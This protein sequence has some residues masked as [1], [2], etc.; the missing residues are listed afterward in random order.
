MDNPKKIQQLLGEFLPHAQAIEWREPPRSSRLTLYVLLAMVLTAIVW[1]TFSEMDKL[2][3]GSGRLVTPLSNLVVQPLEPGILKSID[4]RVGQVVAK[5][6]VLATLDPT[7]ASADT[8][9]LQSRSDTLSLQVGRLESELDGKAKFNQ[10]QHATQAELQAKL[11]AERK[12]TYEARMRQFEESIQRL[13][14]SRETNR[15]D[16]KV[17]G[18]RMKSLQEIETMLGSLET[19]K[20][21]A[22]ARLL[23]AKEKRLEVERDYR[24]A[25]N[26]EKEIQREIAVTEAERATFAKTWRQEA[27]EK[28][29][30]TLQ[31]RDE[32]N[33]QLSKARLRSSLVTLTAS[34]DAI[35]LE[36]GKKSV[37]SVLRDAEPLFT[38]VPLDAP[39][40]LEMEVAPA[41][42]GEIRVGDA[43]RI[44]VDAYPFQK[45]GVVVGK[46][47]NI[48][49]DAFARQLPMGGQGFY[50][51]I[52]V[53]LVDTDLRQL[54]P[55]PTHLLPGMTTTGEIVT[56]KRT[57]ISYFLYPVVRLL[58]E[59]LRER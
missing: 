28:L 4:V 53:S 6:T 17:L 8:G 21:V 52:R 27:M 24:L 15:H 16:Q 36:I 41:D 20:F 48:S 30:T 34:Q 58:D 49:A 19:Q 25:V 40:E 3:V 7:F 42:I 1:A 2:V 13:H 29:S 26:R 5:G 54:P 39:L 56:G 14:A 57:V 44:K 32:V 33:E 46:V 18:Q 9:Q 55:G 31:E 37:G 50:Y 12:A 35:V 59:S 47:S 11:M 45:H 23:E 51:L 43:T 22:R 10:W 38:L